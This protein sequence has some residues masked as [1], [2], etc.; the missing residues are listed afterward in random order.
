MSRAEDLLGRQSIISQ[1]IAELAYLHN[2]DD[3]DYG[4]GRLYRLRNSAASLPKMAGLRLLLLDNN[5]SGLYDL[6]IRL[7]ANCPD[8]DLIEILCDITDKDE[9]ETVFAE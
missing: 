4:R 5:E 8:R 6:M 2:Q 3:F 1:N 9:L 7:R